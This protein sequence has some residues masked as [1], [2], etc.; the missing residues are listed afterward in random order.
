[1]AE[2]DTD[3]KIAE[4]AVLVKP[5]PWQTWRAKILRVL[6]RVGYRSYRLF[7]E[8]VAIIWGVA[9]I[10]FAALN[11]VL[12]QN[13]V[14]VSFLRDNAAI[15]FSEAFEGRSGEVGQIY[16]SWQPETNSI[17]I[18]T[19]DI[20]VRDQ[21]EAVLHDLTAA[22]ASLFLP[23]LL[24]GEIQPTRFQ[25]DGGILTWTRDRDGD[26]ALTLGTPETVD[27]FS[28][29]ISRETRETSSGAPNLDRLEFVEIRNAQIFVKDSQLGL[30]L[31]AKDVQV[32]IERRPDEVSAKLDF[33][34]AGEI[35]DARIK[36]DLRFDPDFANPVGTVSAENLLASELAKSSSAFQP[37]NGLEALASM[38]INLN[39]DTL[40]GAVQIAEGPVRIAKWNDRMTSAGLVFE[41]G[42][43]ERR[44]ELSD[45]NYNGQKAKT[46]GTGRVQFS[47]ELDFA[48]N[49]KDSE[50]R[51]TEIFDAA[52]EIAAL[53]VS[54]RYE[55]VEKLLS[56]SQLDVRLG[57]YQVSTWLD[58]GLGG[59]RGIRNIA[60]VG[61]I[62][63]VFGPTDL[64]SLWPT[65][66][67]LGARNWIERAVLSG[68]MEN[69]QFSIDIPESAIREGR[70]D[71]EHLNLSFDIRDGDVRYISTMD[72]L[73]NAAG[74]GTLY[75][76]RFEVS[77][78][79][80]QVGALDVARGR[81]EI[82]R[83][84]PK[85]SDFTIDVTGSGPIKDMMRL[86]DQEP[87]QFASR[88][89]VSP[90]AF[91]GT[92]QVDVRVTRPLLE[93]FDQDRILY[94]VSGSFEDVAAPFGPGTQTL[95]QGR[96]TLKADRE[97]MN[98]GGTAT[99]GQWGVDLDW[100]QEFA[101]SSP[102]ARYTVKGMVD[103]E[104]LDG[105]GIGMREYIG[106]E[107]MVEI[108]AFGQGL[109]IV[110]AKL[111]ADLSDADLN[112][113]DYWLKP[114]GEPGRLSAHMSKA[115][116]GNQVFDDVS[117]TAPGLDLTGDL[118]LSED[119]ELIAFNVDNA[120][121]E[122]VLDASFSARPSDDGEQLAMT[123]EGKFLD[124][125]SFVSRAL[126]A[127]PND[128]IVPVS[129]SASLD[130]LAL[131]PAYIVDNASIQ[132]D[133]N[134]LGVRS[135]EV[136]GN[137]QGADAVISL[138]P[139]KSTPGRDL[140]VYIP[141]ASNV[142]SAFFGVGNLKGGVLNVKGT[143][144]EVGE[145]GALS[146]E[147]SIE[148]FK[149][150][151]APVFAQILSLASLE[152]LANLLGGEGVRFKSLEVPFSY[153]DGLLSV[154]DAAASGAA[155]GMTGDGDVNFRE[156]EVDFDGVLVPAYTANSALGSIP[157]I[158]DI[159]VGK[160]G[161]G[162]FALSYAVKGPFKQTQISVNP[163]SALTPG[164]LRQIFD[165]ERDDI[166]VEMP[167]PVDE[168]PITEDE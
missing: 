25:I 141:D 36:S 74:S 131:N 119:Y 7:G 69:I 43:E 72:P 62:D 54:G 129:L 140:N 165:P 6:K 59:E 161:E 166:E 162:I 135:L 142:T 55:T 10:W 56:V 13:E 117:L 66:F 121:I 63:G 84:N 130:R 163:F 35:A 11:I 91:E 143:L 153:Q 24:R 145:E 52:F 3:N 134:G 1:M 154:R 42:L 20:L 122:D 146:G 147:V 159:F 77:V 2:I 157:V 102:P 156:Q 108:E 18:V 126:R 45:V 30:D 158:G 116:N 73:T 118:S 150:I 31:R 32:V 87:F 14:D 127:Q 99:L 27:A 53:D 79:E 34:I 168:V 144:P 49:L 114:T 81:V 67:A 152:G 48:L 61:S 17:G 112:L 38:T 28:P 149:L 103:R 138:I 64:L 47:E 9:L 83:L 86:I 155:L 113:G 71:D 82:P 111:D 89:G 8:G 26:Y 19:E 46:S 5:D 78:S 76:N 37:L 98:V 148:D 128:V 151:E 136:T 40:S 106:G 90:D 115:P 75:G 96:L 97:G 21:S 107:A 70:L 94:E 100:V 85:G 105:F 109:N 4:V 60:A 120:R 164:F 33:T 16:M 41:G 68:N 39:G 92:G 29:I 101:E 95:N 139:K 50:L 132:L 93:F 104:A 133:H 44:F 12:A 15:W 125:S 51:L 57:E 123:L 160:K 110:E 22:S 23:D 88:Y 80:G 65:E 137:H 124:V 58:V 167:E